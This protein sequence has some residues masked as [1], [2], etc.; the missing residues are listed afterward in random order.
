MTKS[1]QSNK[2][3]FKKAAISRVPNKKPKE[4]I[5]EKVYDISNLKNE[6]NKLSDNTAYLIIMAIVGFIAAVGGYPGIKQ[7]W[8]NWNDEAGLTFKPTTIALYPKNIQGGD[9]LF[10][11]ILLFSGILFNG[12]GKDLLPDNQGFELKIKFNDK[13]EINGYA[14][15]LP[16]DL[17]LKYDETTVN[18]NNINDLQNVSKLKP[19]DPIN[20]NFAFSLKEGAD[21]IIPKI[22]DE[23]PLFIINC[24]DI[25]GKKYIDS[26][27]FNFSTKI[28]HDYTNPN[29]GVDVQVK[30]HLSISDSSE[31]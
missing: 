31:K 23:K 30:K 22:V 21:T 16:K 24:T 5:K 29:I 19:G 17:K 27:H 7:I 11:T 4:S 13:R 25:V 14:G 3:R 10:N 18:Y 26:F 15:A 2:S 20:G 28:I 12:G 8:S 1:R 6:K 9:S